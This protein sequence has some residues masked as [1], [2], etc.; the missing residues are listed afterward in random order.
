MSL[1]GQ[2]VYQLA[3]RRKFEEPRNDGKKKKVK[4][5]VNFMSTRLGFKTFFHE[6]LVMNCANE[7]ASPHILSKTNIP[8]PVPKEV[9]YRQ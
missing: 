6:V 8:V 7:K 9:T 5:G 1:I 2:A 4:I 3:K